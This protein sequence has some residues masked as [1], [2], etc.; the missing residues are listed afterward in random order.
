M[1]PTHDATVKVVNLDDT[2]FVGGWNGGKYVIPPRSEAFVPFIATCNWFGHPDAMDVDEGHRF[3]TEE[4]NRLRV[5]YGIYEMTTVPEDYPAAIIDPSIIG[6]DPFDTLTPNLQVWTLEGERLVTVLE[7]PYGTNITPDV[8][9]QAQAAQSQGAI[10]TLM[11]QVAA[12]QRQIE[13]LSAGQTAEADSG[14]IQHDEEPTTPAMRPAPKAPAKGS[15]AVKST[16]R[17]AAPST[18]SDVTDDTPGRVKV[19]G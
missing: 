5:K 10:E 18:S 7:D 12:L 14:D 19:S 3:R 6:S 1:S 8:V 11:G 2:P 4:V 13:A 17:T 16:G 9:T 15:G